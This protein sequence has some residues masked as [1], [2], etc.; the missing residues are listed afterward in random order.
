MLQLAYNEPALRKLNG[1]ALADPRVKIHVED[2]FAYLRREKAR[3]DLILSDLPFPVNYDLSLLFS[4][5]FFELLKTRLS[6]RG[7]F[8]F[9]F[10]S[11]GHNSKDFSVILATLRAAGFTGPFAF[12]HDDMFLAA[13]NDGRKLGFDLAKIMPEVDDSV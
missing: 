5:E 6:G 10:P 3:H 11:L 2:A 7:L 1:N 12:G 8:A 13:A 4:R 9:D